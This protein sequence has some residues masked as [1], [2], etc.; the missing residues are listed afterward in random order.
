MW[1]KLLTAV[2]TTVAGK[3]MAAFGL[4]F[5]TYVGVNE[6]QQQLLSYVTNQIGGISDDALQILYI[7]GLGVCLNWIFG[8]FTFIAS[9]KSFQN[10][11]QLCQKNKTD[12]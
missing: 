4:S 11:R 6:L 10:S 5:V 9:L 2:L 3:I 1:S 12:N 8:T 7:T